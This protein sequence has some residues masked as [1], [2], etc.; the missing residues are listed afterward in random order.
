[1]DSR[2]IFWG[3]FI[4][5]GFRR[6]FNG[7]SLD[8]RGFQWIPDAFSTDFRNI[9]MDFT[10]SLIFVGLSLCSWFPGDVLRIFGGFSTPVASSQRVVGK[11]K[12]VGKAI[13]KVGFWPFLVCPA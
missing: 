11:W 12:I 9:F 3:F 8:F 2:L 1:M 7:F 13:G 6:I 5:I 4:F 10:F